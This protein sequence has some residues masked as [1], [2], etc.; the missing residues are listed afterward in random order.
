MMEV[1]DEVEENHYFNDNPK[2]ILLYEVN[3]LQSLTSYVDP[4]EELPLDEQTKEIRLQ[5]EATEKEIKISQRVQASALEEINLAEEDN[6][7]ETKTVLI[8]KDMLL[9][10]KQ[11]LLGLLK[12]YKDVFAS[13]FE[14]MKSLDPTFYQHQINLHKDAKPVQQRR[15]C[16]NPNYAIKVKKE[17][18]FDL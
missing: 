2:I 1:L 7:P 3:I 5:Q 13:S 11:Q 14:D 12:Q 18:D 15:Y 10:D 16:L 8:A 17:I 4:Q 9:A 6:V